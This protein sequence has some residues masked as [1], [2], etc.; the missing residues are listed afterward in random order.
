MFNK[1][2]FIT[3]NKFKNICDF[4]FFKGNSIPNHS[5]RIFVRTEYLTELLNKCAIMSGT[6]VIVAHN[7]DGSVFSSGVVRNY[8]GEWGNEYDCLITKLP[9]NICKLYSQN[10]NIVCDKMVPI[11]IGF[12][13]DQYYGNLN[14]KDKI[15][16]YIGQHNKKISLAYLNCNVNNNKHE[17]QKIFDYFKNKNWVTS[18]Y[19]FNGHNFDEYLRLLSEHKFTLSPDGHGMDTHRTWEALCVGSIPIVKRHVFSEC[20]SKLFPMLITDNFEDF[21]ENSL[22]MFPYVK[23]NLEFMKFSFWSDLIQKEK[24]I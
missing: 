6:Y 17:R 22:N 21:T 2:D 18:A 14:K 12:E 13:N 3:G 4:E 20:F 11:P 16:G 10:L 23:P 9:S 1:S 8:G 15:L 19:G 5:C 24:N 7:S